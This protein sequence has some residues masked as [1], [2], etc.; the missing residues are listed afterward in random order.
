MLPRDAEFGAPQ[1]QF[2]AS[3]YAF[4]S[5]ETVIYSFTRN[6]MWFLGR[7]DLPTLAASDYPAEFASISGVRA[8]GRTVV[9]RASSQGCSVPM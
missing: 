8:A 3:T 5:A 9:M 6:G 1:W 2:A 4:V 7:L